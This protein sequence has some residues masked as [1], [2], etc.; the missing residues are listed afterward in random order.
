MVFWTSLPIWYIAKSLL[1]FSLFTSLE[2]TPS[3]ENKAVIPSTLSIV[4]ISEKNK[5]E[6]GTEQ[7]TEVRQFLWTHFGEPPHHPRLDLPEESLFSSTDLILLARDDQ[8]HLIGVIRYHFVG[9]F[10]S[11]IEEPFMY[12]VDCFCIHP[13]WRKKGLGDRLL[14]ELHQFAN[15]N[16]K[17]FALF[18][19]EGPSLSIFPRPIVSGEYAYRR[20]EQKEK[21]DSP[22]VFPL[23]PI[24]IQRML[25]T[26]CRLF[27]TTWIIWNEHSTE[28]QWLLYTRNSCY[29]WICIQPTHQ[30][31]QNHTI[32][33][34]T[35]WLES[36]ELTDEFRQEAIHAVAHSIYHTYDYLW[37]N[38][39]WTG[40]SPL[41]KRDGPFHYYAFQWSSS[42]SISSSISYCMFQ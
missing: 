8:K 41:W 17:P 3:L 35:G 22:H 18:L 2:W 7:K 36:S 39:K 28:Q 20:I 13:R 15:E 37:V 34:I 21:F 5:H 33:W 38:H 32:G 24:Q 26:Y 4:R 27:P 30:I 16:Q 29:I 23:T 14:S 1:P 10:L 11:C 31:V 12:V 40:Q 25:K 6:F 9:R 19:K 42:L